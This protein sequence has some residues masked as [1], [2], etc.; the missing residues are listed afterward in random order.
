MELGSLDG[1]V[2]GGARMQVK[3]MLDRVQKHQGFV[4]MD[5][6]LVQE[7]EQLVLN[8]TLEPRKTAIVAAS[9]L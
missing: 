1:L 8:V 4:C 6:E 9:V 3:R 7:N 5:M 2:D